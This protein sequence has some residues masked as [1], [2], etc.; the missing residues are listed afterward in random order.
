M[1]SENMQVGPGE[2]PGGEPKTPNLHL[3]FS[4]WLESHGDA[5]RFPDSFSEWLDQHGDAI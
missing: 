2:G 3:S 1:T 5:L 4:E